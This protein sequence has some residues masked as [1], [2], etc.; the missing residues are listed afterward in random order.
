MYINVYDFDKTIYDGDSTLDFYIYSIKKYPLLLR[1]FPK[2]IWGMI[3]YKCG[4]YKK[5]KFKEFFFSFLNGLDKPEDIIKEFWSKNKVK[6]KKWYLDQQHKDDLI[7]SA[8]PTFLLEGIC[9]ELGINH[10]LATDV[11]IKTGIFETE[12]C[13]G[14]EKVNRMKKHYP[15]LLIDKFYSDSLTDKPLAD[16]ARESYIV[17]G[18]EILPWNN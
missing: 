8:S 4:V 5:K 6:I 14:E 13:Y 18:N 1:Y 10:L 2:Q 15:D 16:L 12:N 17:K 11:H 3:M 7:I 9:K